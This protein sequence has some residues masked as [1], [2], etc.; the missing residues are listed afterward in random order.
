MEEISIAFVILSHTISTLFT[1]GGE[2]RDIISHR[3]TLHIMKIVLSLSFWRARLVFEI[4]L[5]R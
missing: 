3:I 4:T 1:L 5:G 2:W